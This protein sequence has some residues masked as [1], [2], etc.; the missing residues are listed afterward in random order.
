[1]ESVCDAAVRIGRY[2]AAVAASVGPYAGESRLLAAV[3]LTDSARSAAA[4]M[5][6]AGQPVTA[7]TAEPGGFDELV[8]RNDLTAETPDPWREAAVIEGFG[9]S[10]TFAVVTP[11]GSRI[12][13]T[14]LARNTG[15]FDAEQQSLLKVLGQD[16][17][18][19]V[20]KIMLAERRLAAEDALARSEE[21]YRLLFQA[22]PGVMWVYDTESLR[23][24]EVNDAAI[25]KYGYSRDRFLHMTI[26][27]IRPPDEI[28]R[29]SAH[30]THKSDGFGDAGIWT[31][32]DA[33]GRSFPVHLYTHSIDWGDHKAVVVF[34][35]EVA[36]VDA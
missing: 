27:D 4:E 8:V 5:L 16:V 3:G 6:S 21:H 7:A 26:K 32:R 29:L 24:L 2:S 36:R 11:E 13:V 15:F 19:A 14:L 30:L 12:S 31:H 28:E 9:S 35:E 18:F 17:V 20:E 10:A 22:N 34:A 33:S 23:F 25:A 1:M